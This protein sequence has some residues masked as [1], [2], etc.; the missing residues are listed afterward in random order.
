MFQVCRS[1][2]VILTVN[3]QN[4]YLALFWGKKKFAKN[5]EFFWSPG[6]GRKRKKKCFEGFCWGGRTPVCFSD[7]KKTQN[8]FW[9]L[10]FS[11]QSRLSLGG[12]VHGNWGMVGPETEPTTST[13][14]GFSDVREMALFRVWPLS[15]RIGRKKLIEMLT[16]VVCWYYGNWNNRA[17]I[18]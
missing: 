7:P 11:W 1:W 18:P 5:T 3:L 16:C 14:G 6:F 15:G 4:C 13:L 2:W 12:G 9:A 17:L 8:F 10:L